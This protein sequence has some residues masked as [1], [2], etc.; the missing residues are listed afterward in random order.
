MTLEDL[1]SF[2]KRMQEDPS[3]KK[4]VLA[5][6]TAD[7][8]AQIALKLGFELNIAAFAACGAF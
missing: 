5:S 8:V 4:Q 1:K 2:L 7:D 6:S 3:L